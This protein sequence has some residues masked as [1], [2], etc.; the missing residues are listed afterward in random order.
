M[1]CSKDKLEEKRGKIKLMQFSGTFVFF[2]KD[3]FMFTHEDPR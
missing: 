1:L 2:Y 3:S